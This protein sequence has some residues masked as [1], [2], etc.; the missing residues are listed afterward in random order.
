[1]KSYGS[2]LLI[3]YSCSRGDADF[4]PPHH[5]CYGGSPFSIPAGDML[6]A[7]TGHL[8]AVVAEEDGGYTLSGRA[9]KTARYILLHSLLGFSPQIKITSQAFS[10]CCDGLMEAQNLLLSWDVAGEDL[11]LFVWDDWFCNKLGL[12]EAAFCMGLQSDGYTVKWM[13]KFEGWQERDATLYDDNCNFIAKHWSGWS[14]MWSLNW[15]NVGWHFT[16]YL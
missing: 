5:A 10:N 9:G 11:T 3:R 14:Y 8:R 2:Q 12:L 6:E 4:K 7:V 13:G 16:Y 15:F 1:M